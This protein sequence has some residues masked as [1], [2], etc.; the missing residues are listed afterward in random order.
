MN[1]A[2]GGIK[3]NSFLFVMHM[4]KFFDDVLNGS[5]GLGW[6]KEAETLRGWEIDGRAKR[7]ND[8]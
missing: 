1:Y 5:V 8:K 4:G 2:V 6:I 7:W 3:E